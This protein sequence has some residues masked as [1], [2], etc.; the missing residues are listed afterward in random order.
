MNNRLM[1]I[2]A[3]AI[4]ALAVLAAGC[5]GGGGAKWTTHTVTFTE[6]QNQ[7]SFS[8]ADNPPTSHSGAGDEPTLSNGDGLSFTAGLLD[9]SGK[10]VGEIDVACTVTATT[11]GSFDDS[12]AQC[13][14]TAD[15]PGGSLTLG[16]GGKAFGAGTTRGA[17]VGG[18][19][20]Y[21]GATG[22]FT[23]SD[24]SGSDRPS[25]DTF[26]LVVPER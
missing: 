6:R 25:Q 13:V 5:G 10:T 18:T 23:S 19:G 1:L 22:T 24:E 4:A 20:D 7:D 26:E 12:H 16:V 9:G 8:F 3:A 15:I 17:V 21:A 2:P 11:T 14:G